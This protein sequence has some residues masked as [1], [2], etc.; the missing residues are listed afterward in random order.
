MD[1][2]VVVVVVGIGMQPWHALAF[3]DGLISFA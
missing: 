3:K 2:V 1:V